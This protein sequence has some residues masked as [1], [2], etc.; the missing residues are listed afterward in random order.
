MEAS[1]FKMVDVGAKTATSRRAQAQG[2]ICLTPNA[3]QAL[4]DLQN[5]KGNVLALAESAGIMAAKNVAQLLPLCHPLAIE[6]VRVYF[7][8]EPAHHS[9]VAFCEVAV[10]AKTGAEMEALAG[11]NGA[12]LCIYDLSKAVDP[13]LKITDIRLNLKSG[14][15]S[16]DWRHPEFESSPP[17]SLGLSPAGAESSAAKSNSA[18]SSLTAVEATISAPA[19]APP[20]AGPKL[21]LQGVEV[22]ALT[23]S[24]RAS[25]GLVEDRSGLVLRE[26]IESAGGKILKSQIVSDDREKIKDAFRS[27]AIETSARLIIATGGTGL[28]SRDVTPEALTE[29]CERI[30]P[31][32]GELLRADGA[33]HIHTAW[34]SRAVAGTLNGRILI[35][36]PGSPKAVKEGL[37]VLLPLLPHALH[38]MQGGNHEAGS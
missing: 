31:G 12:L 3:M 21:Y 6:Q 25:L 13:V 19:S 1:Y 29:V 23:I 11:V 35:A 27:L 34:L 18:S 7:E 37:D 4:V 24:D 26:I 5:P 30:I 2:R 38:T 15:K 8:L 32:F 16:G 9:V 28:S 17:E 14:G 36:L 22:V 20:L 33:K 10:T